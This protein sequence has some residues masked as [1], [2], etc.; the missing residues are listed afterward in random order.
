MVVPEGIKF[1]GPRQWADQGRRFLGATLRGRHFTRTDKTFVVG[2][3]RSGTSMML[4][5][6]AQNDAIWTFG[7]NHPAVAQNYRLRSARRVRLVAASTPARCVVFKPLCDSQW[8]DRLL[9][10]HPRSTALWMYRNP[11]DVAR[12]AT[13]K[14]ADHQRD[15][16]RR[17]QVR[18]WEALGWRGERLSERVL[19]TVDEHYRPDMT[20]TSACVLYWWVRNQLFFELNLDT[21]PRVLAV[22]Y[23]SLVLQPEPSFESVFSFLGLSFDPACVA[24]VHG[25]SVR[26]SPMQELTPEIALLARATR[27]RLDECATAQSP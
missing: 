14:W 3:Q 20:P 6:L 18:D 1:R 15:V 11:E 26:D 12:S 2:C 7:E 19:E 16:L 27:E 24:E 21:E 9:I 10:E 5:V 23:E 17:I 25:R 13:V 4:K 22:Q 8:T